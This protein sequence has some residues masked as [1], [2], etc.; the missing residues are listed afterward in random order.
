MALSKFVVLSNKHP[1]L[2]GMI[3]YA[4]MW[5]T[6]S[7][8]QQTIAGKRLD[9]YDWKQAGRF[10]VFGTFYVAPILYGWVKFTSRIWPKIT[11]SVSIRKALIEQVTYGPFAISSFFLGM[12]LL[13]G[14]S[15]HQGV[16]EIK[17]KFLPTWKVFMIFYFMC[18]MKSII[19]FTYVYLQ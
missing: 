2:R 17:E 4:V 6:S 5:P 14:K 16:D 8:I 7:L 9:S 18:V 19:F 1:I 13:E 12:S 15:I 10:M 3:A 11:L